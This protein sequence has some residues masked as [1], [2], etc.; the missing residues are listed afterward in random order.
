MESEAVRE[1]HTY[2]CSVHKRTGLCEYGKTGVI[3]ERMR[4]FFVFRL[5]H[6]IDGGG[7]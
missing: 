4:G 7:R 1:R 6:I 3:A 2:I 5:E